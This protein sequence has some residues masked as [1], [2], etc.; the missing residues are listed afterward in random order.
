M[1]ITIFNDI[2]QQIFPA[3]APDTEAEISEL[4]DNYG[5]SL[6]LNRTA[7]QQAGYQL[8][9]LAVTLGIAIISGL[10]TGTS[11]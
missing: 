4:R 2:N 3:R 7:H 6:G 8:L 10:I 11:N 5:I 9:S 1:F